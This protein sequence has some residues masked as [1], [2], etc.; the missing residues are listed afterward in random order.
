VNIA[1]GAN[2][3]PKPPVAGKQ[4]ATPRRDKAFSEID[5]LLLLE[6]L[7]SDIKTLMDTPGVKFSRPG[8]GR[9]GAGSPSNWVLGHVQPV[10]LRAKDIQANLSRL[11]AIDNIDSAIYSTLAAHFLKVQ[12]RIFA[13]ARGK[14][15][16]GDFDPKNI[17]RDLV[18]AENLVVRLTLQKM[19]RRYTK[20][21][22]PFELSR[23][24][25]DLVGELALNHMKGIARVR[26]LTELYKR[27]PDPQ[28]IL[29]HYQTLF[30]QI[31]TSN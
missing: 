11:A 15:N 2:L 17:D 6:L 8:Q 3:K 28:I 9:A 20:S 18:V 4:V 22:T 25:G 10:Q 30:K 19:V 1:A 13:A 21:S 7:E 14:Q 5:R 23:A 27:E 24:L 31:D 16:P 26:E 29:A 12:D